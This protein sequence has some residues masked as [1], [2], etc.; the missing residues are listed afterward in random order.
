MCTRAR[1]IEVILCSVEFYENSSSMTRVLVKRSLLNVILR[2]RSEKRRNFK[3]KINIYAIYTIIANRILH[4][5]FEKGRTRFLIKPLN[6]LNDYE[7]SRNLFPH[8]P[9]RD[10]R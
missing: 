4:L 10:D 2:A 1:A 9:S 3:S 7:I 6:S 8:Y 5:S